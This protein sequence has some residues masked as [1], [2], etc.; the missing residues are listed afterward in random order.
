MSRRRAIALGVVGL[1]VAGAIYA[2]QSIPRDDVTRATVGQAVREFRSDAE[3]GEGLPGGPGLGVYRYAID[4]GESM[5]A[6][7][8]TA[9]HD[10]DG[11]S[12]IA[13][14]PSP[15]GVEE[16]WQILVNRWTEA[17]L[18]R[19]KGASRLE[20]LRDSHEFY[21]EVK[22]LSYACR[23]DEIPN[24]SDLRS[25][26]RWTV[27][28]SAEDAS[29]ESRTHAVGI[30]SI[31]IAGRYIDAVHTRSSILL[32]G[33]VSGRDQREEWRRRS[34]GLLLRR[35]VDV[36]ANV[37]VIGSADYS[38]SYSLTLLSTEPQR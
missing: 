33:E 1:F 6:V 19:A 18:C 14:T 5:D 38:E 37:E 28:C 23:G 15:C 8:G 32:E 21:G 29:I 26:M 20:R 12:T 10:Y 9:G 27:V 13:I 2:W 31:E 4:G 24:A 17:E 22:N 30:E 16:R 36:D 25:G 34:D 3:R 7:I 35:T 11:V